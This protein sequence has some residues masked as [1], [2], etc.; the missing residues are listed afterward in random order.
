MKEHDTTI[1]TEI[2]GQSSASSAGPLPAQSRRGLPAFARYAWV[3]VFIVAM[4]VL[5]ASLGG[6]SV[7]FVVRRP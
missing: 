3:C 7:G 1:K 4:V 6:Y 5:L 2:A